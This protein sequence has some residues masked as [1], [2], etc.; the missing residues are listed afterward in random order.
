MFRNPNTPLWPRKKPTFLKISKFQHF[1][2]CR[3]KYG[4]WGP[5]GGCL[6]S[7]PLHK[8]LKYMGVYGFIIFWIQKGQ[9]QG[10]HR[11]G[12]QSPPPPNRIFLTPRQIGLNQEYF[13]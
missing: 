4:F 13:L 1:F 9:F 12:F 10:E 8:V 11:G 6:S 3:K 2:R 5:E 7:E